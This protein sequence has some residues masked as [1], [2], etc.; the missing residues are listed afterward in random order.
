MKD[1]IFA[2]LHPQCSILEERG[3]SFLRL[4]T[5]V[6]SCEVIKTICF[7]T[8]II[9]IQLQLRPSIDH[10]NITVAICTLGTLIMTMANK[11]VLLFIF[12][13]IFSTEVRPGS[14]CYFENIRVSRM[15]EETS[16]LMDK[17]G[18]R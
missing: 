13:G 4:T 11:M 16:V 9:S 18:V 6:A 3:K 5:E 17:T 7:N 12:R 2:H 14:N 8:V 15:K 10:Q 1:K